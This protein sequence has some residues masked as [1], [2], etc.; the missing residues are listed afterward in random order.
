MRIVSC[1][2]C[3]DFSQV[4]HLL[5]GW[6][7]FKSSQSFLPLTFEYS[8]VCLLINNVVVKWS[9]DFN[10]LAEDYTGTLTLIA[11]NS[12]PLLIPF[13]SMSVCLGVTS[14][15]DT[16]LYWIHFHVNPLHFG[17]P[18]KPS[19]F[20]PLFLQVCIMY[21][22][23]V[24]IFIVWPIVQVSLSRYYWFCFFHSLWFVLC[25]R[26][27]SSRKLISKPIFSHKSSAKVYKGQDESQKYVLYY[28]SLLFKLWHPII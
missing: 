14:H 7:D 9:T 4:K 1:L 17:Y 10:R 15:T 12:V 5:F 18:I 2:D 27:M 20:H 16:G 22:K 28:E 23:F 25:L 26:S 11:L 21:L 24:I 3:I 19:L 6:C 13:G 8:V